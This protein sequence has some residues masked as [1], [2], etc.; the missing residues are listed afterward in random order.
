LTHTPTSFW[1]QL[2]VKQLKDTDRSRIAPIVYT[3]FQDIWQLYVL[4]VL[5]SKWAWRVGSFSTPVPH[6]MVF[7]ARL[8]QRWRQV[9]FALHRTYPLESVEREVLRLITLPNEIHPSVGPTT[10]DT[11]TLTLLFFDGGSR[12]NPGVS[13]AGSIL[14]TV[15]D[16]KIASI[17]WV[18]A[19]AFD[20][21]LTNNQAEYHGLINGLAGA[22]RLECANLHVIGDSMLLISQLR[23]NRPPKSARIL[24]LYARA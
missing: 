8:L 5:D 6:P 13:G 17:L 23:L 10:G 1:H 12:G 18:H 24:P 15:A 3:V 19:A 11:N 4:A 14:V 21:P 22:Q 9:F 20:Q 16:T 7:S 2:T